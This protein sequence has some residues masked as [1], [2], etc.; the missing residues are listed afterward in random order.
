MKPKREAK[1]SFD[2]IHLIDLKS[3]RKYKVQDLKK[4]N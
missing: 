2:G 1:N 4:V 3:D